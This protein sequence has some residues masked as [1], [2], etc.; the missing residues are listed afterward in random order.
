MGH[1][2]PETFNGDLDK[3]LLSIDVQ[4]AVAFQR[5]V[6]ESVDPANEKVKF[7]KVVHGHAEVGCDLLFKWCPCFVKLE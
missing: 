6:G 4:R 1:L 7:F 2:L 5:V 3:S